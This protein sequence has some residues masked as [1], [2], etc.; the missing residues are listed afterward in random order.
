MPRSPVDPKESTSHQKGEVD[1]SPLKP[2]GDSAR[3][4]DRSPVKPAGG[5]SRPRRS[6][7][8]HYEMENL[9]LVFHSLRL[10]VN[11]NWDCFLK[12]C[13]KTHF[14]LFIVYKSRNVEKTT[15]NKQRKVLSPTKVRDNMYLVCIYSFNIK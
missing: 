10:I 1:M 6:R 5:E 13:N 3:A 14:I 7:R 15:G 2:G 12:S 9:R 4:Y 11:K 8:E